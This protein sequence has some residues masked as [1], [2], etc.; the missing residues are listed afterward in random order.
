MCPQ[1]CVL[2][3]YMIFDPEKMNTRASCPNGQPPPFSFFISPFPILMS[4]LFLSVHIS[5]FP[6]FLDTPH[7]SHFLFHSCSYGYVFSLYCSHST[8]AFQ[9]P[10]FQF[11]SHAASL[12]LRSPSSSHIRPSSSSPRSSSLNHFGT[13]GWSIGV[14]CCLHICWHSHILMAF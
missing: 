2:G 4:P 11:S 3:I 14:Y 1:G 9:S 5:H 10:S 8:Q 13:T 6:W 12:V 7:V